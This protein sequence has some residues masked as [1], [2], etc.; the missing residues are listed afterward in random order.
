ME[1]ISAGRDEF[2]LPR[3]N[4]FVD[5]MK[6]KVD[7]PP[8]NK[9]GFSKVGE[10]V[11]KDVGAQ[12]VE[13]KEKLQPVL[14][15]KSWSQILKDSPPPVKDVVFQYLPLPEG[16]C[17]VTPPDEELQEGIEKLKCC[18]IGTFTKGTLPL[19]VVSQ[20]ASKI[21]VNRGL[22]S[23]QKK[24]DLTFVFK[25][26][27]V[28][29]KNAI[30]SKG[31]WYFERRPLVI[32]NWGSSVGSET[33][34][35]L[36]L[37]IKLHGVPDCYWTEKGLSRLASVVGPPLCADALTSKL[38][39]LPYASMCVR[40]SIGTALPNSITAVDIDPISGCKI[41]VEVK[42][43]YV[44]KPL[45]CT[46]CN[47]LGH[48]IAACPTI[49]RKWVLK[50]SSSPS[51]PPGVPLSGSPVSPVVK[52]SPVVVQQHTPAVGVDDV[53]VV[54]Q[55][56]VEGKDGWTEV[57]RKAQNSP[58]TAA[59]PSSPPDSA[60][61]PEPQNVFKKLVNVDEVEKKLGTKLSKSARKRAKRAQGSSAPQL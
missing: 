32:S 53:Q 54:R 48:T 12:F 25:F 11:V 19:R 37:W 13:P 51:I 33:I 23:V 31:T 57:K 26:D 10:N 44:N 15:P 49:L 6:G 3:L 8:G 52:Q 24:N 34:T 7:S 1:D 16:T 60:L 2:G 28:A 58:Q 17:V 50:P 27:S 56:S 45:F 14:P 46:G 43:T 38:E 5:K 47:S 39:I 20:V 41:N 21:W 61:S 40:Y 35:S 30:L 42:I 55:D 36:P 59:V 22:C 9:D 4:P 18:V 29:N